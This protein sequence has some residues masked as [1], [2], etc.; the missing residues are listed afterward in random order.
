MRYFA[1]K[2]EKID[3]TPEEMKFRLIIKLPLKCG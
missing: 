3:F 1:A 2:G